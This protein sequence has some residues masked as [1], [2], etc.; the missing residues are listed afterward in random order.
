MSRH[1][2]IPVIVLLLIPVAGF[3]Q[4]SADLVRRAPEV[5]QTCLEK[6]ASNVQPAGWIRVY[7]NGGDVSEG[8]L[9][10]I[11]TSLSVLTMMRLSVEDSVHIDYA[12]SDIDKLQY[13]S[14]GKFK[15]GYMAFGL[16][17][18]F[19]GS[20]A[21]AQLV[22]A[23]QSSPVAGDYIHEQGAMILVGM[24]VGLVAGAVIPLALPSTWT[25]ECE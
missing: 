9:T 15:P 8:Q 4:T 7:D 17:A 23:D 25:I 3:T 21:V 5:E 18:G 19:V 12:M 6:A 22:G 20:F 24:G 16:L 2:S 11:D 10:A 14:P 1:L 13:K